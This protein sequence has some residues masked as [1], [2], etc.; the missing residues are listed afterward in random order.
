MLHLFSPI[1]N[2][3]AV[4]ILRH[5]M[6]CA[7]VPPA[8]PEERSDKMVYVDP[9]VKS[10]FRKKQPEGRGG[11]IRL[12]QNENPDGLPRWLFD[13]VMKGITPEMLGMYPEEGP[14]IEKYSKM[15][16]ISP[17]QMTITDGSV[18]AMGYM[19]KVFGEPG[20]DLVVV[21]PTFNMYGAYGALNGMKLK[22]VAYR[23]GYRMDIGDILSSIDD[24]TSIVVLVN[25]NMPIG[26]SYTPEEVE[27]VVKKAA[28]HGAMVVIDEA[29]HYFNGTQSSVPLIS[30]YDNVAVLRTFSK[31]FSL[32][33]LRLG[34][35]MSSEENIR[36]VN[37]W[38][39]HYTVN[40]V[41]LAFG[42][43]V[44]DNIDR[45][46]KEEPEKFDRG[47][48]Y[49]T[50]WLDSNGYEYIPSSGC[51]LCIRPKHRDAAYIT[52]E[53]KKRNILILC[54][55]N[56]IEGLLRLT[57]WDEKYMRMFA[58]AMDAIDRERSQ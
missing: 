49:I 46:L 14:F 29:Y 10:A 6:R 51:F 45:L 32:A 31:M 27:A 22:E 20:K 30:K 7:A 28:E 9:Y 57:V 52:E 55:G 15:M 33:G 48:K 44:V 25:P 21:R 40:A 23:D 19:M 43:A 58:D 1:T 12:D 37:N 39:P 3:T 18:V 5:Q 17:S 53:L 36:Y 24:N 50:G 47:M 35:V 16:G 11:F 34:I 26:N 56:N 54:G 4:R 38:R 42:E 41:T 8:V 13:E 2:K